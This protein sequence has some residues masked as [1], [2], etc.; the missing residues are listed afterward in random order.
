VISVAICSQKL[1]L[2]DAT[3][4]NDEIEVNVMKPTQKN[5][6]ICLDE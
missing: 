4:F 2:S 1:S 3:D 6:K 5:S